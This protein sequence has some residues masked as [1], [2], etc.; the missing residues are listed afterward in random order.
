MDS[1][2]NK[3]VVRESP[4]SQDEEIGILHGLRV[5]ASVKERQRVYTSNGVVSVYPA[6]ERFLSVRRIISGQ[7]RYQ[8]LDEIECIVKSAF[9]FV[10]YLL[11]RLE[12]STRQ[13]SAIVLTAPGSPELAGRP[14]KGSDKSSKSQKSLGGSLGSLG[15][16]EPTTRADLI[17]RM[18]DQ[19]KIDRFRSA[20]ESVHANVSN[21][22]ETYRDDHGTVARIELL[23]DTIHDRLEQLKVSIEYLKTKLGIP[24][25]NKNPDADS[26]D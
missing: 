16:L 18:S 1:H 25:L 17:S 4:L 19:Q 5:I 22:I 8:N 9:D 10:E 23:R 3:R 12:N 24:W 26:A 15:G 14:D 20:I 7:S 13:S 6:D 21:L 11:E 2:Q